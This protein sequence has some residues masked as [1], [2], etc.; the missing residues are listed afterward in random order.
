[1]QR[2]GGE[3]G[4][5]QATETSG[6][7]HAWWWWWWW[8]YSVTVDNVCSY[9]MELGV[10]AHPSHEE[11]GGGGGGQQWLR[12]LNGTVVWRLEGCWFDALSPHPP[13]SVG[14]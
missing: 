3:W 7:L 8:P 10:E 1:M 13:P 9:P 12:R 6:P 5:L 4:T 2:G 14:C 11:D